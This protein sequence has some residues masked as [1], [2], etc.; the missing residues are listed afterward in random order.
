MN[1][2]YNISMPA[3]HTHYFEVSI[4][5]SKTKR[6]FVDFK[7]AAWTPGSYLLREYAQHVESYHAKAGKK[8][9]KVVKTAKNTWRV[10]SDNA[11][12][13]S[14]HYRVYAFE[15][16]VRN[17]FLDANHGYINPAALC[18]FVAGQ[19]A[20]PVTLTIEPYHTWKKVTVPLPGSKEPYTYEVPNF[21]VL[22]D[23]PIEIGNHQ[24]FG[25]KATGIPHKVAWYGLADYDQKQIEKD[26][27]AIAEACTD[28]FGDHPCKDYLT[29]DY[30][31]IVH[32]L[33]KKFGGLEHLN[34]TSLHFPRELYHTKKGYARFL[35]LT[36]HEYFHLWNVKR[37]RPI[38]LGP[39]DYE[40]EN[41]TRS[42]W[43]AEGFTVYYEN[44]ILRKAGLVKNNKLRKATADRITLVENLPGNKVQSVTDS[45]WDAWIKAYRPNENSPNTTISYYSKGALVALVLDLF[46]IHHTKAAQSLDDVMRHLYEE[47]YKKEQRGFSE[48]EIKEV[49]E[50]VAGKDLTALFE[51]YIYGTESINY[52]QY[53]NYA[54]MEL[55]SEVKETPYLGVST[56]KNGKTLKITAIR[57]DSPAYHQGLNVHDEILSIDDAKVKDVAKLIENYEVGNELKVKVRRDGNIKKFL[58]QLG[59]NPHVTYKIKMQKSRTAAQKKAYKKWLRK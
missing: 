27:K 19:Q 54:G 23:S 39:F 13:F 11:P 28:I 56:V 14:F 46:I 24:E 22:V 52:A 45:S 58:I 57:K 47:I 43:V 6:P 51:K 25:F 50:L 40:Q 2:H 42:L 3:P 8:Q 53:L 34:S 1:I 21:D 31:F 5:I 4:T 35:N 33:D 29:K 38:E 55:H 49:L 37:I 32:I 18:M 15:M 7:M 20:S 59:S 41:Y 26:F 17:N 9:L 10:M 30:T 16:T 12:K 48:S 36:A 44:I